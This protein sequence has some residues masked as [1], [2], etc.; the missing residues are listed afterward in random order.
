VSGALAPQP[1]RWASDAQLL[2]LCVRTIG[3]AR[4]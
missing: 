2:S 1:S 4:T 3:I